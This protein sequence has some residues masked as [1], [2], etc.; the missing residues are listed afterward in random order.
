MHFFPTIAFPTWPILTAFLVACIPSAGDPNPEGE[1]TG[2]SDGQTDSES[3]S[4]TDTVESTDTWTGFPDG[5]TDTLYT[6]GGIIEP[7]CTACTGVGSTLENMRC[8]IDLCDDNTLV[9]QK[10]T[11]PTAPEKTH[12]TFAAISRLGNANNDLAPHAGNSYAAIAS[13]PVLGTNHNVELDSE[14]AMGDDFSKDGHPSYDVMEWR[15][16]L[17]APPHAK[18]F[19]ISYIF[20][21]AEYDEYVGTSYNDKFYIFLEAPSTNSGAKSVINFTSCRDPENYSDF[22]CMDESAGCTVGDKYCYIAINTALSE[23]CWYNG[24]PDGN[25]STSLSGTGFS[26][27]PNQA[28]DALIGE[29][30]TGAKYGSSTGW[31]TTEWPIHSDEEF[32]LTFHIHDT[33]DAKLDSA[34]II[35][36]FR[37]VSRAVLPGTAPE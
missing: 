2:D 7:D 18:G 31:L 19:Q 17:K 14:Q 32:Y 22:I 26:C 29:G 15:L 10:Y 34:V 9:G 20:L 12:D 35:D 3:D 33:A 6:D 21:S 24:C 37:F 23:C 8:A 5:G 25:A 1:D 13:G 11:S 36:G 28:A 30:D 27:A 16:H 4:E